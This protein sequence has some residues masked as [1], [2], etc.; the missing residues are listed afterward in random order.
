MADWELSKENYQPLRGGRKVDSADA[1][2]APR[3]GPTVEEQRR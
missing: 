3:G 2:P 1:S